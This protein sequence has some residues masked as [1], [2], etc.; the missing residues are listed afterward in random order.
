MRP[1]SKAALAASAALLALPAAGQQQAPQSLL[2][3]GFGAAPQ[4]APAATPGA[5]RPAPRPAPAPSAGPPPSS[6]APA[7]A[8]SAPG[9]APVPD[10]APAVGAPALAGEPPID[11]AALDEPPVPTQP[12]LP[13]AARRSLD[14][15][16]LDTGYGADVFGSADGRYLASLMRRLD[17]PIASRWGEILLR[18]M[19]GAATPA[20]AGEPRADWVADRAALLLRLG[21]ADGARMLV[22]RVDVDNFSPRLRRVAMQSAF[23]N[24]DAAALCPLPDGAEQIG[25]QPAWPMIRAMCAA[26]AGDTATANASI[27]RAPPGDPIDHALAEK[28]VAAG[29]AGRRAVPIDW[30]AVDTLTDWRF[31]LAAALNVVIPQ[32]LLDAAPAWFQAWLARAPM[33]KAADRVGP[34]RVA[35]ALGPFSSFDLVD[36]YGQVADEAGDLDND[37]PSGRLRAAYRADDDEARL[38]AMRALWDGAPKD[39]RNDRDRYAAAILT[40]RAAVGLTPANALTGELDTIVGSLFADGLDMQA[41]RWGPLAQAGSDESADRAWAIL[42]VGARAPLVTVTAKRIARFAGRGGDA[43]RQR[44]VMLAAA[45]AALGRL[46]FADAQRIA[47]DAGV[48]LGGATPYARALG[49]AVDG[50][51]PGTVALLAAVGLQSADWSGVPAP[52]FYRMLQAL[53]AAGLETEARM[54]AAEAMTRL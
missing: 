37:S 18:R 36:L 2:P 48:T 19:L 20:P 49:R 34:A 7:P 8:P 9:A 17:A 31:G 42:A 38:A 45:L 14:L 33:L 15:V 6:S 25:D 30:T 21:E 26:L 51:E 4:P 24:A 40:G 13:Q 10:A 54:I 28:M 52:A 35:A 47:E 5:A 50:G 43:G 12:E 16:G 41:E 22:E 53:R 27:G 46:S 23:A 39:A 32:A 1:R 3:P 11:V 29:G 44:G